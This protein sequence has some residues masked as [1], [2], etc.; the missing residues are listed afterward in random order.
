MRALLA[1][2]AL[3]AG[4]AAQP[5]SLR[6]PEVVVDPAPAVLAPPDTARTPAGAVRRAL[7]VPGLGQVYNRQPLKAP[8]AVAVVVGAVVYA[9]DRQRQYTRFRRALVFAG[10][11]PED[12]AAIPGDPVT[13]P[14]RFELCTEVAPDYEDEWV[15]LGSNSYGAL[16]PVRE[17]ARGQRD[18]G[19]LVVGVAYAAQALEAYIAAHLAG[20]DVSEDL[21]VGWGGDAGPS[22]LSVRVRL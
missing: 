21:S 18:V 13:S 6:V 1:A 17:R 19:Y 16:F 9:V 22:A 5:D 7:L 11:R 15:A 14:E 3:T 20:F 12:P 4:A 2:L 10:C 8:V